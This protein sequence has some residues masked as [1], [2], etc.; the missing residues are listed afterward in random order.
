MRKRKHCS[1]GGWILGN[2]AYPAHLSTHFQSKPPLEQATQR[3]SISGR[4]KPGTISA[5]VAAAIPAA[6]P[7]AEEARQPGRAIGLS[8]KLVLVI[9]IA[10]DMNR[11][12]HIAVIR[13]CRFRPTCGTGCRRSTWCISC[14]MRWR[15]AGQLRKRRGARALRGHAPRSRHA[16]LLTLKRNVSDRVSIACSHPRGLCQPVRRHGRTEIGSRPGPG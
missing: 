15:R 4:T 7:A 1:Y 10:I 6:H 8:H 16:A 2:G 3:S 14:S 5:A 12:M 9:A 11:H 13:P